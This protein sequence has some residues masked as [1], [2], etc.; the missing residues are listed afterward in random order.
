MSAYI[1]KSLKPTDVLPP[2]VYGEHG[3]DAMSKIDDR[4]LQAADKLCDHLN[5][6]IVVNTWF[7]GEKFADRGYRTTD[8]KIGAVHSPHKRGEALDADF[9]NVAGVRIEP[10]LVRHEILSH[11]EV[12]WP[13]ITRI[14]AGVNW[15]HFDCVDTDCL[16]TVEFSPSKQVAT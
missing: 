11:P 6:R 4:I 9:Y 15:V 14:E 7:K 12:F 13:Y 8:S 10:D 16:F 1:C 3:D 2:C 5:A